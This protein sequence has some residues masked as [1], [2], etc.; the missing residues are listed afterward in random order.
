MRDTSIKNGIKLTLV[1]MSFFLLLNAL[2]HHAFAV[3]IDTG[4][5]SEVAARGHRYI[6]IDQFG[7]RPGD[8]K[9]AVIADPQV[10][11]N[12]TDSFSP[13]QTYQVRRA[14]DGKIVYSARLKIFNKGK[15]QVSSGDRGYWFD[16]SSV[17]EAGSFYLYD[18]K[19]KVRSH[20]FKIDE[21]VYGDVLTAAVRMFYYN[22]SGIAKTPPFADPRWTDAA[23]Y[24][25]SGQDGEARSIE[26]KHNQA[27]A[28][29]LRGGWYDAGDMNKYV[30]NASE[31]LH[32]LLAAYQENPTVWTDDYGIPESGNG[33]P[34]LLDEIRW[35]LDWLKRMQQGDGGMLSK[36]GTINWNKVSPPGRDQRPRYYVPSCSSSTISATGVFAHA[37]LVFSKM[38]ALAQEAPELRRRAVEAWYWFH[39]NPRRDDCDTKEVKSGDSDRSL[40][41]QTTESVVAAIYL[42]ASTGEAHYKDHVEA[43]Y[44]R[45]RPFHDIGWSRYRAHEGEALLFYSALAGINPEVRKKIRNHKRHDVRRKRSSEIYANALTLDLYRAH[46]TSSSY[47]WGSNKV[48]ANYGNSNLD[49]ITYGLAGRK[50]TDYQARALGLLHYLHGV[51]PQGIVYLSNMRDYGAEVSV[52]EMYHNWFEVGTPWHNADKSKYGPAPGYLVGGPNAKYS[53]KLTPPADQPLQK[54]FRAW[55]GNWRERSWEISEPSITYQSAYVKLLSKFVP[56]NKK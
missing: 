11:H 51:N 50:A 46:I 49:V 28:R 55:S 22:R 54:A 40:P 35:E 5:K 48:R 14:S 34:D 20:I 36:V 8:P 32:Q 15:V 41:L 24:L 29:D 9:I 21:N 47:H 43:H 30:S 38:P 27:L 33:I 1:G 17:R 39:A 23:S 7:Y 12:A 53:G 37:A 19:N 2:G 6:M 10:G 31:T 4:V 25:G 26:E 45:L 52:A 56:S 18:K 16:F 3:K 42:F 44:S 13:G